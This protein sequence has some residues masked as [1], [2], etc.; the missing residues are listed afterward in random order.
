MTD[1]KLGIE[2][3]EY[4]MCILDQNRVLDQSTYLQSM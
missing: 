4:K 1:P 3:K 2:K